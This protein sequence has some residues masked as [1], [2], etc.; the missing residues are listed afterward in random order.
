MQAIPALQDCNTHT[1]MALLSF[2]AAIFGPEGLAMSAAS[3]RLPAT[4]SMGAV[5]LRSRNSDRL[6][7]FY[8]K[9]LGLRVEATAPSSI[10]MGAGRVR[11]WS[12]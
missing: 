4:L 11:W 2:P 12:F 8:E 9:V 5:T 7:P 6:V 10:K 3:H 1:V